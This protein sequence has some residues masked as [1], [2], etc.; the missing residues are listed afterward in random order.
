M[1]TITDVA[2]FLEQIAPLRL[3]E[4]WDN[5]GLLVGRWG[6]KVGKL[7]TCLTVT[8]ESVAEAV[9]SGVDLIVTH[10]PMPFRPLQRLT[11]DTTVGRLLLDLIAADIAVYSAHTAFDSAADG[12]NQRIAEGL[13]LLDIVPLVAHPDGQGTGRSGRFEE[14]ITLDEL[15]RRLKAFLSIENLMTVGQPEQLIQTVA[16]GCG[17]A[18]ELLAAAQANHCDA[19]ILGEARFH[20]CLEAQAT[21]V[22]LLL[23]GHFASERFAV[24]SLAEAI[25]RKFPE[26]TTWP[27]RRENDPIRW[28]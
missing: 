23:P 2:A 3:A 24:E 16:I 12:I 6:H 10:H 22:S 26:I 17:A 28:R 9:E 21:G 8:R 15:V 1:P 14:P 13:E 7:M 18:D 5:V 19:M 20:T 4:A 11:S 27:S 25:G